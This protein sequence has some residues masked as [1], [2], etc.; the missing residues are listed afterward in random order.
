MPVVAGPGG[1]GGLTPDVGVGGEGRK[2]RSKEASLLR[3]PSWQ[4]SGTAHRLWGL[5]GPRLVLTY[6]V[7]SAPAGG[8]EAGKQRGR[9]RAVPLC[10]ERGQVPCSEAFPCSGPQRGAA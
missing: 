5:L 3:L 1:R 7:L 8:P 9:E 10:G 2:S 6:S 4:G